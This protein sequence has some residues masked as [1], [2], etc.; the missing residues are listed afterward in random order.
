MGLNEELKAAQ[1]IQKI[2]IKV[3]RAWGT[4]FSS[5][6]KKFLIM[7]KWQRK[8]LF[9]NVLI[10]GL[11]ISTICLVYHTLY[12]PIE[13][14]RSI[15]QIEKS[16]E[17]DSLNQLLPKENI[18]FMLAVGMIESRCKWNAVGGSGNAYWG[19]FQFGKSALS[20]VGLSNVPQK[21]F[22]GDTLLQMWAM[23]SLIKKNYYVLQNDIEK[24][25]IPMK[26]GVLIGRYMCT[27]SGLLA[28]SH[29]VGVNAVKRFIESNGKEIA[30]DGNGVPLTDY[31]MLNG[32]FL[33]LQ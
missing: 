29:L 16:L 20:S 6:A 12:K 14:E 2:N 10:I 33:Y 18:E 15:A 31:L 1:E 11:G 5:W 25:N 7:I 4:I 27:V 26:G 23:N 8:Q 28:A 19:A 22:L 32:Y 30:H 13:Q 17:A 24:Y 9:K 21:V 3:R